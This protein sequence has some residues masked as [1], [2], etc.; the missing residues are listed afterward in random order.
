MPLLAIAGSLCYIIALPLPAIQGRG[1][2]LNI[3][4]PGWKI[5]WISLVL[6]A[7]GFVAL[8]KETN[9]KVWFYFLPGVLNIF[10]ILLMILGLCSVHGPGMKLL[11]AVTLLSWSLLFLLMLFKM[12]SE[13]K[14]GSFFWCA[15]CVLLSL[16]ALQ[17]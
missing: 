14:I 17:V 7:L 1:G 16:N 5:L 9:E 10:M 13:L 11:G 3:G 8:F 2:F 4:G 6:M 15:A 12:R